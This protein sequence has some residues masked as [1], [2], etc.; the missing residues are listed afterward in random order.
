[1][2]RVVEGE[3]V[4]G[5]RSRVPSVKTPTSRFPWEQSEENQVTRQRTQEKFRG[6]RSVAA[7]VWE[8]SAPLFNR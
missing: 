2:R 5:T 1:M 7:G 8:G 4:S 6:L 3:A